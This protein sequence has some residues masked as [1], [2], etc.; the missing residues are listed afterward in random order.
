MRTAAAFASVLASSALLAA[1][2][3][4]VVQNQQQAVLSAR[5]DASVSDDFVAQLARFEGGVEGALCTFSEV[6]NWTRSLIVSAIALGFDLDLDA[7][8]LISFGE[9]DDPVWMSERQ[10]LI[11]KSKGRKFMDV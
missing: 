5:P 6:A 1:A 7:V 2:A 4:L 9:D 3:P 8:R 10:K 11:E